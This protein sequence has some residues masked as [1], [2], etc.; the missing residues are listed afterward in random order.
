MTI[1]QILRKFSTQEQWDCLSRTKRKVLG[2]GAVLVTHLGRLLS[3]SNQLEVRSRLQ[4]T[5]RM[6]Y[7]PVEILLYV[8]S[9]IEYQTRLHSCAKEPEMVQ[10]IEGSFGKGEVFY[11][12]GANVGAYSLLAA[13]SYGSDISV[14]AFEPAFTNFAQ[15]CRNISLNQCQ[16][17]MMPL[18]V[19]LSDTTSVVDF[20]YSHLD[21]GS[22]L[23]ALGKPVDHLGE[24]FMPSMR[25]PVISYR[26]DDLMCQFGLPVPNHIKMDVDGV[27]FEILQ[28]ADNVLNNP[29]VKDLMIEGEDGS[30][31]MEKIVALLRGKGFVLQEKFKYVLAGDTGKYSQTHNFLF[32]RELQ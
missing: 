17:V 28:G 9:P 6:D 8:D 26:L 31:V 30:E 23:H 25:L 10:W 29:Q 14:Y 20:N 4:M 18:Q 2:S 3:A 1:K 12:I 13:K 21:P 32:C 22:G 15:L 5:G 7:E 16:D 24:E 11:D 27:E 19:G